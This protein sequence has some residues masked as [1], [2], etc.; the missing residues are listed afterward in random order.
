M[1]WERQFTRPLVRRCAGNSA[2]M[3]QLLADRAE[4]DETLARHML[5][6]L[7]D[8]ERACGLDASGKPDP[9]TIPQK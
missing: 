1:N 5:G 4:A 2:A 3:V 6:S 8:L 9:V 7:L